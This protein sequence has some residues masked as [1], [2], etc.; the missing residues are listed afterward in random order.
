MMKDVG[1]TNPSDKKLQGSGSGGRNRKG[2]VFFSMCVFSSESRSVADYTDYADLRLFVSRGFWFP[3]RGDRCVEKM[4]PKKIAPEGQYVYKIASMGKHPSKNTRFYRGGQSA[5]SRQWETPTPSIP[6][7]SGTG[8]NS[9]TS[10]ADIQLLSF[11]IS[12]HRFH[13]FSIELIRRETSLRS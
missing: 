6:L 12:S 11:F 13:N 5:V 3:Q 10:P 4:S 7:I 8:G 9:E 1:V 2:E